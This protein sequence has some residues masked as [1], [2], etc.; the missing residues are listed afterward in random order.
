MQEAQNRSKNVTEKAVD[1]IWNKNKHKRTNP[2]C[3]G[4]KSD[5]NAIN[6]ENEK[7]AHDARTSDQSHVCAWP[8]M[9]IFTLCVYI[10]AK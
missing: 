7:K 8:N 1:I 5:R 3:V 9:A 10:V 2:E 6:E 4:K